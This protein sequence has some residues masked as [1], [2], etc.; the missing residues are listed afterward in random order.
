MKTQKPF[1]VTIVGGGMITE[2]QILPALYHLQRLGLI[3]RINIC[4]L[5]AAPLRLI[6]GNQVLREAFPG[7][8]FTAYP[9]FQA[10]SDEEEFPVLYQQ[11]IA[12]MSARQIVFIALPDQMH[13]D[14]A[15]FALRHEQHV[16]CVKPLTLKYNEAVNIE[17]LAYEK[18]LFVGV[19]YH[20]RFDDR[21][22]IARRKYRCG[23]FG[24]FRMGYA[25]LFEP[26]WYRDSNFQNWCTTQNSDMFTYIGCHYVDQVH[27][28][29]GLLPVQ[30]SV[31]GTE[32]SY[33]NGNK[34]YL[35]T[36]ARVIWENGASL[37]VLNGMGYP[38]VGPGG[39]TQGIWLFTQG[40]PDDDSQYQYNQNSGAVLQEPV[41]YRSPVHFPSPPLAGA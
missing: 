39:N 27:M 16:L 4:A 8:S 29:T 20:K 14:A 17:R 3:N 6:A 15:V 13:H 12:R 30:V 22:G 28:I 11:V 38:N 18:G 19:E 33:P 23:E 34:G 9:D 32:E 1:D 5:N 21:V 36:N 10:V 26:W 24:E 31:Y 7:H 2:M 41:C 37:A 35:W 40:E 25:T